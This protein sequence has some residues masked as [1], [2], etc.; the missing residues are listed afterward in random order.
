MKIILENNNGIVREV[1]IGFSWTSFFFGGIPFFFR[2]MPIHGIGWIFLSIITLGISNFFICFL[3]NKQTALYYLD[4]GYSVVGT[5][6]NI[7]AV[8]WGIKIPEELYFE[9]PESSYEEKSPLPLIFLGCIFLLHNL[10]FFL[11]HYLV[12]YFDSITKYYFFHLGLNIFFNIMS[13]ALVVWVSLEYL[14]KIDNRIFVIIIF[15]VALIFI[16]L[17]QLLRYYFLNL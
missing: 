2:G 3:I 7:P 11:S 12:K 6:S 17:L 1:K 4:N 5:N 13:F 16:P 10:Y 8:M 9:L 15:A 14:K